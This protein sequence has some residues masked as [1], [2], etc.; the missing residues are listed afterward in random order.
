[1]ATKAEIAEKFWKALKSDRT[2]MLGLAGVEEG[3]T[4]PM[5]AILEE[6][7]QDIGA[8]PIWFFTATDTDLVKAMGAEQ[9]AVLH[10]A[11]KGHEL[12]A[13]VHGEL[14]R[15]NDRGAIDRLWNR[16]I[17]AWYQGGKDDPKL[18]LLRFT[19]EHAQIWLNEHSLV[20]GVKLLLGGDPK[21]DYKN[22]VAEMNL[23]R[24]VSRQ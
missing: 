10:F 4:Q 1:M 7:A 15:D 12:F 20:A 19:P 2:V 6:D 23:D 11:S 22:K 5:T 14:V 24:G 17:A 9:R 13:S 18:Q 21:S 3:Q 16:F 8:G